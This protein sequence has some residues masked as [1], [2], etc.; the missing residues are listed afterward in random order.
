MIYFTADYNSNNL[1]NGILR[2]DFGVDANG[3][4]PVSAEEIVAFFREA[5]GAGRKR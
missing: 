3:M 5:E 4:A 1:K 2:Y